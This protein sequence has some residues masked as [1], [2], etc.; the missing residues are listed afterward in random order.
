MP[1]YRLIVA[2]ATELLPRWA[3]DELG[4]PRHPVLERRVVP[5][6]GHV[7]TRTIR[8]AM[9]PP[10]ELLETARRSAQESAQGSGQQGQAS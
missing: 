6:V 10:P 9:A 8:W 5:A 2:A 3:S 7:V 1:G 4:L